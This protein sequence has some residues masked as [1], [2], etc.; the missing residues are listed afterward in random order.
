MTYCKQRIR[1]R[2]RIGDGRVLAVPGVFDPLSAR[3][4]EMVGME[5]V[6]AGSYSFA[7]S[8]ALPD[9]GILTMTEICQRVRDI[10]SSVSVPIIADAENGF[11][12]ATGIS[13]VIRSYEQA[14]ASAIH[15]EDHLSGKHTS[16]ARRVVPL[17]EAVGKIR[18]AVESREDSAFMIIAR[19]DVAWATGRIEDCLDRIRAFVA[20]GADAVMPVGLTLEQVATLRPLV[21]V[22]MVIVNSFDDTREAVQA[23]GADVVIYHSLCVDAAMYGVQ[24]ALQHLAQAHEIASLQDSFL[25]RDDMLRLLGYH[26]YEHVGSARPAGNLADLE[27]VF[28]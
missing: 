25:P 7:S 26:E 16:E 6:H 5:A 13:R 2:E 15:I 20:A 11:V 28:R 14:G 27:P 17:E 3:Q 8:L 19:T 22:P 4:A 18:A 9:I 10:A 1:L 24:K 23:A 12:S 21:S